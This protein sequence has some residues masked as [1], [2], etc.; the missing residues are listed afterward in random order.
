[1]FSMKLGLSVAL[2]TSL[3]ATPS[4]AGSLRAHGPDGHGTYWYATSKDGKTIHGEGGCNEK[5]KSCTNPLDGT[6]IDAAGDPIRV[7]WDRFGER[8]SPRSYLY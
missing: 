1:M 6:I 8:S 7:N 4:F 2:A 5:Y 3:F